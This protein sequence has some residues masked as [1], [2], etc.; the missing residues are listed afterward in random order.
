MRISPSL[1]E[2]VVNKEI[3]KEFTPMIKYD[4]DY[5]LKKENK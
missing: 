1:R 4:Y 3:R 5:G 2:N